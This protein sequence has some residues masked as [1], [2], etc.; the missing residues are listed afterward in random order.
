MEA[1]ISWGTCI[2]KKEYY[3]LVSLII[4]DIVSSFVCFF[5]S[6]YPHSMYRIIPKALMPLE[7]FV[8]PPEQ[9]F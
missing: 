6:F 5:F 4:D 3:F 8:L 9:L 7:V 1:V 2:E